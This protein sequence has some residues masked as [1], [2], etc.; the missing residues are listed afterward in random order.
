MYGIDR[1]ANQNRYKK[2][3][4]RAY[5]CIKVVPPREYATRYRNEGVDCN[6]SNP[7]IPAN[8]IRR[9]HV[10]YLCR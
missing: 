8:V 9:V 3:C 5:M 10:T 6:F 7:E 1:M 4:Q 2:K